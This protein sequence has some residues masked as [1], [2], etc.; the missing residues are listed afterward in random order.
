MSKGK[1][2]GWP[3]VEGRSDDSRFVGPKAVWRTSAGGPSGIAIVHGAAYIGAVTGTRL[4]RV[5]LRGAS[6]GTPVAYL[7][8]TY[9]RLRAVARS[10][11]NGLWV[12]TS[13]RDANG[14][15]RRGDDR[16]LRLQVP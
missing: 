3:T 2:Y 12:G 16:I 11:A 9:G 6:A 13:N 4:Y 15:P 7:T 5:P 1:N 14:T 10:S 8:G